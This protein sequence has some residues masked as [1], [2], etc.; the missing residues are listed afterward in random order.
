MS[1]PTK[2]NYPY[3]WHEIPFNVGRVINVTFCFILTGAGISEGSLFLALGSFAA[4]ISTL[5]YAYKL[6]ALRVDAHFAK[7]KLTEA[8]SLLEKG[9]LVQDFISSAV[10]DLNGH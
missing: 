8:S 2:D 9:E 4:L 5:Y 6:E 7:L 1:E 10:E 3:R